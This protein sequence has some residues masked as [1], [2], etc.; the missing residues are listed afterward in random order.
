MFSS[1]I[2]ISFG[3][4]APQFPQWTA[5][6]HVKRAL[7]LTLSDCMAWEVALGTNDRKGREREHKRQAGRGSLCQS[8]SSFKTYY[9]FQ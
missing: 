7:Y 4:E 9:T 6:P 3:G 5:G 1:R 2:L 8:A